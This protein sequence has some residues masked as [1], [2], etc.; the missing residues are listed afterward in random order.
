MLEL[1][2]AVCREDLAQDLRQR[3]RDGQLRPGDALPGEREIAEQTGLAR[4]TVRSALDQLVEEGLITC[5]HGR[6]RTVAAGDMAAHTLAVLAIDPQPRPDLWQWPGLDAWLQLGMAHAAFV[7]GWHVLNIHPRAADVRGS[8]LAVAGVLVSTTAFEVPG[9]AELI[10]SCRQRGLAVCGVS[11]DPALAACDRAI[12]DHAAGCALLVEELLRRGARRI[13]SCWGHRAHLDPWF[14]RARARGLQG[15]LRRAGLP[16]AMPSW[17]VTPWTE[18]EDPSWADK[19]A[20]EAANLA[21]P[22]A[23]AE[24]P[25]AL[26]ATDDIHAFQLAAALRRLGIERVRWPLIAGYDATARFAIPDDEP[27]WAPDLSIDRGNAQVAAQAV[28]LIT[29][30][31]SRALP[32]GPQLQLVPPARLVVA[33]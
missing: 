8:G 32:E 11:D 17:R 3:I 5:H 30:R 15:V 25:Q 14:L 31:L 29:A 24:P 1:A 22:M 12:H 6:R 21:G 9:M 26:L 16:E 27:A 7:R 2:K 19:V 13:L 28:G 18:R 33:G 23:A 10:A 20:A 4:G